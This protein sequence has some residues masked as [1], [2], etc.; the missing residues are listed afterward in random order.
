M[1]AEDARQ[2]GQ[3]QKTKAPLRHA[4]TWETHEK[5]PPNSNLVHVIAPVE[6]DRVTRHH[7]TTLR[8]QGIKLEHT[9]WALSSWALHRLC[10]LRLSFPFC[11]LWAMRSLMMKIPSSSGLLWLVLDRSISGCCRQARHGSSKMMQYS[12]ASHVMPLETEITNWNSEG[13]N[14]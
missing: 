14:P 12:E 8:A 6:N 11:K 13:Q 4:E 2:L 1:L 3:G 7:A 5:L 10:S 9:G